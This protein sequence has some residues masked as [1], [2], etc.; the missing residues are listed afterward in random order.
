MQRTHL[1]LLLVIALLWAICF[2]PKKTLNM[3]ADPNQRPVKT[4]FG[5]KW[6]KKQI[7]GLELRARAVGLKV[8]PDLIFDIGFNSGTDSF[9][10]A[11]SGFSVV[12]V[13]ANTVLWQNGISTIEEKQYPITL[14][15]FCVS[16][17]AQLNST[18]TFWVNEQNNQFSSVDKSRGCRDGT[19]CH[20]IQIPTTTCKNVLEAH[21]API[22]MKIDIDGYH[23]TC[24]QELCKV[25]PCSRPLYLSVEMMSHFPRLQALGYTHFKWVW[26][27]RLDKEE[28]QYD[29]SGDWG[30]SLVNHL[31]NSMRWEP[32]A[33]FVELWDGPAG[34]QGRQVWGDWGDVHAKR[35]TKCSLSKPDAKLPK[36]M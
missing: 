15:N 20:P 22:Y 5:N 27:R 30:E 18:L 25:D 11:A 36:C 10:Y 1:S 7:S 31:T 35:T 17:A 33:R 32:A 28:A 2:Q 24:L 26:G 21:G 8:R 14:L 19:P 29:T 23:W 16:T 6:T 3:L 34:K 12:S 13:E 9:N 4:P